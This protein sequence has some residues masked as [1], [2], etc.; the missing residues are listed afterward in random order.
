MTFYPQLCIFVASPQQHLRGNRTEHTVEVEPHKDAEQLL[1]N[2]LDV[3]PEHP[4]AEA[5]RHCCTLPCRC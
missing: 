4:E 2:A 5:V 1:A 3:E